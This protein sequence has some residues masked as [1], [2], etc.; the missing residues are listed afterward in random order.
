MNK[1]GQEFIGAIREIYHEA[2]KHAPERRARLTAFLIIEMLDDTGEFGNG[3]R[4]FKIV[5]ADGKPVKFEH[6]DL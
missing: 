2:E 3:E 1:N 5:T 6:G 4:K